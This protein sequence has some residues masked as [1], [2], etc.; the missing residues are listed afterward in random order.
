M[1][2]GSVSL[3]R[4]AKCGIEVSLNMCRRKQWVEIGSH[5]ALMKYMLISDVK[6]GP[7]AEKRGVEKVY[8]HHA[9]MPTP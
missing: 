8:E 9:T 2:R 7:Q 4:S 1:S 6:R 5:M 3:K